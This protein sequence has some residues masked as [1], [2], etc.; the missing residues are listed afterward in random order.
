MK[1][2]E[3]RLE[4]YLKKSSSAVKLPI[5]F[6]TIHF[7]CDE[8]LAF[9]IRTAACFGVHSIHVIG[10]IPPRRDLYNPS[11]SLID[12]VSLYQY[13]RP[14]D[15]LAYSRDNNLALVSAEISDDSTSLY[16]YKFNLNRETAIVLG[17]ESAGIPVEV[18]IN[19]D[20]VHIPMLGPGYCLNTSQTGTSLI[21]EYS[22]QFFC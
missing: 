20:T 8:N 14:S 5:S 6:V 11:G 10:S 17:N 3:T 1:R 7:H 15:F 16:N 21:T 22:R 12:F 9:L 13:S 2:E 18:L 4:R 19:S